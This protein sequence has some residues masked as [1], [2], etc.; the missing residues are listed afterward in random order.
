M[1]DVRRKMETRS[2]KR[3][4]IMGIMAAIDNHIG[5]AEGSGQGR[6]KVAKSS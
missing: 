6:H 1:G 2:V 4:F 5:D 3:G